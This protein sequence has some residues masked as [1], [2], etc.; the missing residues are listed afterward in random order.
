MSTHQTCPPIL[1]LACSRLYGP[2]AF[3]GTGSPRDEKLSRL[4][5]ELAKVK[6]KRD[7]LR[8]VATFFAGES[9]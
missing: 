8:E 4:K 7:F 5:R 9:P 6:K 2:G 1:T 3:V